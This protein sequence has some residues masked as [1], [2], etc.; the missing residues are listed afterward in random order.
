MYVCMY[1]CIWNWN[2]EQPLYD[3]LVFYNCNTPTSINT[4]IIHMN[5]YFS[6]N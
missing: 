6:H 4:S 1:V 5:Y 3:A 2:F